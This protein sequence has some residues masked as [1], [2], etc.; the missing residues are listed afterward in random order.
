[1]NTAFRMLMPALLLAAATVSAHAEL[2]RI[3]IKSTKD[4]L[5]GKPWGNI[6]AYEE[7]IGTAYFTIDPKAPANRNIPNIDK[8][9]KNAKGMIEFSS[10]I[11]IDRPKDA[12]KG[13][14]VAL[15]EASNRGRRSLSTTFSQPFRTKQP[16]DEAQYGD[17]TLF[18]EGFTLVWV[19]WQHSVD[20]KP[21]LVGV[22]LPLAMENGKPVTGRVNTFGIGAP[23]IILKDSPTLTLD[24]DTR[25]Y[26][27]VDLNNPNDVLQVAQGGF[28]NPTVI[29]RDQWQ[30]SDVE[31][32]QP[33]TLTLKTGFKTGMRYDLIYT[34]RNTPVLGLGYTAQRDVASAFRYR[35]G[36]PV[37]AKYEYFYGASQTGRFLRE[38]IYDGFVADEQGRKTFDAIWPQISGSARGDFINPFSLQDGLGI[39]TGSMFP[40]SDVP[41][42]D[43]VTGKVDG[44]EMHMPALVIPKIIYT[45][46]DVENTGG[47][48][49]TALLYTALDGKTELKLPDNVRVYTWAGAQH[50]PAAF[51]PSRGVL[52]N[53]PNP[54]NY[55][56]GMRAIFVAM[57]NWVRNGIVPPASQYSKLSDGTL[58]NHANLKFP[59]IPGVQSPSVIPGGYMADHG[60]QFTAPKLPFLVPNVDADGNDRAGLRFPEIAVPLATYTG[61]N[62]RD[63][64]T[65][66]PTEIVPLQGSFFPFPLTKAD[67]EKSGDPRLSVEERYPSRDAY[68][69]KVKAA[70][71]DLVKGRYLLAEDEAPLLAHEAMVWDTLTGAKAN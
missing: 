27:P 7:L 52:A 14:S 24:P 9:P 49:D 29:P 8:A 28:D 67:R 44:M 39:F 20:R 34:A 40:Y 50:G 66:S 65:G 23:W 5:G 1:M 71:D 36:M 4:V 43:P 25:R 11:Y 17:G 64:S 57:D 21:G 68:L 2:T 10:D 56:W 53:L 58:V 41:Q 37:T 55:T 51:P 15:V 12:A 22:D 38:Y 70:A 62:F 47:G 42:K 32:G 30:F 54:N 13:N 59:K 45:N 63:P 26:T 61:W 33:K 69:A 31:N 18:K 6:G 35:T 3:D 19:G 48:R 46:T 60:N 16:E